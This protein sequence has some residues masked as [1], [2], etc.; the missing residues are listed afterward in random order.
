MSVRIDG[1]SSA[2][3]IVVP[4]ASIIF[5]SYPIRRPYANGFSMRSAI[6]YLRPTRD[7]LRKRVTM[8]DAAAHVGERMLDDERPGIEALDDAEHTCDLQAGDHAVEDLAIV[9]RHAAAGLEDGDAAPHL[10]E[11]RR[12]DLLRRR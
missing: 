12:P 3:R 5:V 1:S 4:T 2:S 8:D 7:P 11:D 10:L 9:T 6:P